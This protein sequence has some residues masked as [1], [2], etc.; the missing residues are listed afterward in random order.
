[1][2]GRIDAVAIARILPIFPF[3]GRKQDRND[4]G[5]RFGSKI[6]FRCE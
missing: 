3:R 2:F 1:M 6:V 5:R 4:V